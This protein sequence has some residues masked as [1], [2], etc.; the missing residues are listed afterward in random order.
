MRLSRH[1][2]LVVT[3]LA[4]VPLYYKASNRFLRERLH[5]SACSSFCCNGRTIAASSG[6]LRKFHR[7]KDQATRPI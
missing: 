2:N 7:S 6:G 3:G 5:L 4:G 1:T